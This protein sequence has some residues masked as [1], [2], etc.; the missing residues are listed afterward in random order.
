MKS[1]APPLNLWT[2]RLC[3]HKWVIYLFNDF[4]WQ[5]FQVLFN[6]RQFLLFWCPVVPVFH[7]HETASNL[8]SRASFKLYSKYSKKQASKKICL[9]LAQVLVNWFLVINNKSL[10]TGDGKDAFS[11]LLSGIVFLLIG[12]SWG[13]WL[14]TLLSVP[15][16]AGWRRGALGKSHGGSTEP[17]TGQEH[18]RDK[19][20]L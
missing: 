7:C 4:C 5:K 12:E 19:G 11:R 3:S 17:T 18:Q 1:R 13:V 15:A 20:L 8:C 2:H 10:V 16:F 6:I 14:N 9:F